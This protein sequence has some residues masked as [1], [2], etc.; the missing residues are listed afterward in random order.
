VEIDLV[1]RDRCF[2]RRRQTSGVIVHRGLANDAEDLMRAVR[3]RVGTRV[4]PV[5]RLDRGTSGAVVMA[6]DS[7]AA[8]TFG[9]AFEEGRVEKRYL[10]LT[11]GHP[12][13]G[14]IDHPVPR[15]EG[16]PKV[17]AVTRISCL[18]TAGRYALVEAVPVTG[19]LHQIRRHLKHVSCRSSAT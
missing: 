2:R 5:H 9:K 6:L 8:R 1:Y 3:D 15:R 17:D 18:G 4:Y 10:A 13:D 12:K 19:R 7:E 11:R 14:D 16:G